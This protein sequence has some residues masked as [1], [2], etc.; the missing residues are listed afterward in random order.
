MFSSRV[1]SG[2]TRVTS[3]AAVSFKMP[4]GS[5][6]A[7][8]RISPPCGACVARVTPPFCK[9]SV[10]AQLTWPSTRWRMTGF[11][12]ATSSRS[13]FVGHSPPQSV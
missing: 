13:F 12:G 1:G 2:T 4:V 11:A 10:L 6:A 9:A 7:S 8:C 5:P 3:P